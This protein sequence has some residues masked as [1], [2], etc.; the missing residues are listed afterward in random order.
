MKVDYT[1][2]LPPLPL[3][4]ALASAFIAFLLT[5]PGTILVRVTW[6]EDNSMINKSSSVTNL[7]LTVSQ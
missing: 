7:S 2:N 5:F 6:M 1:A 4:L 3:N